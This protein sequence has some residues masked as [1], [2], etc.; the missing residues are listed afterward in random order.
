MLT[1]EREIDIMLHVLARQMYPGRVKESFKD[2]TSVRYG[3]LLIDLKQETHEDCA[4]PTF[5]TTP[6]STST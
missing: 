4:R 2:A 6:F 5:R 3:F 1:G